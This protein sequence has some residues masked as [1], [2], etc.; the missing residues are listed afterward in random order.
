[1]FGKELAYV[2][3]AE[4][5]EIIGLLREKYNT[6]HFGKELPSFPKSVKMH[7]LAKFKEYIYFSSKLDWQNLSSTFGPP[8]PPVAT[9]LAKEATEEGRDPLLEAE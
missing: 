5:W 6:P 3:L 8:R 2:L 1:M 9:S 4:F 7:I